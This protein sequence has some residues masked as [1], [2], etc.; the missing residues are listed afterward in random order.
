MRGTRFLTGCL[1]LC[2]LAVGCDDDDALGDG[3][4]AGMTRQG[5]CSLGES[6][7]VEGRLRTCLEDETGW[8]V[9]RC[10]EGTVCVEDACVPQ[11]CA[12]SSRECTDEGV[13]TCA[14]DGQSW[15]A[16]SACPTDH[17]CIDG[18]CLARTCTPGET[19]CG[20]K[21]ALTC[22]ADGLRWDRAPCAAAERCVDGACTAAPGGEGNCPAG[23]ILCAPD[24]VITCAEDGAS[25]I[26]TPC[27]AGEACF[28]GE[29]VA[30]LRDADC[31]EA[32]AVCT[33]GVCGPPPLRVLTEALP[34]AQI[35][36]DYAAALEAEN[37]SAPYTWSLA[38]GALP[39][40]VELAEDGTIG[41]API[42]SGAFAFT[43]QVADGAEATATAELEL[44][45]A[46]PGLQIVTDS[47]PEG[48]E[49]EGY[50]AALEAVG[51]TGPYGWLI[52]DGALPAG[53]N[54]GADGRITGTPTEVGQFPIRVRVVDASAPPLA[55]ERDLRLDI[56]VAP[57]R[58]VG[59]Q[60]I[61]LVVV[62]VVTLPTI[63]VVQNV[64]I[65]YETQLMA[66]GGLR[67]LTWTEQPIDENLARII[68]MSG[69]PEGLTLEADGRLHGAVADTNAIVRVP[70]PFTMI[71]LT[72]F[73][74]TAEVRDSQPV[75]DRQSAIFLLP[76]LPIGG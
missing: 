52:V 2:A 9:E 12:P 7:C 36:V 13:R 68:P 39:E 73:F 27:L 64:P 22:D 14:A 71:E 15:S 3:A 33:D 4:D 19:A 75:A 53:L 67:P 42:E 30:C 32:G 20:D 24:A 1:A 6:V 56:A 62:R 44:V 38:E 34:P 72:G 66:R 61:D 57:L 60:V 76:T 69:L 51:G 65:P 54:L 41:G 59:D 8:L 21:V 55:T 23:Q 70:I 10:D 45:V 46:P 29:C 50:A 48:E 35:E 40:G 11:V 18:V 74:F 5:P 16:P 25:W 43:V 63:T 37:G 28:G 26:E 49:G 17:G 31:A 47:L 58:I